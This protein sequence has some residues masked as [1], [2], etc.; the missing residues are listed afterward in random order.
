MILEDEVHEMGLT[1]DRLQIFI[2]TYNRARYLRRTLTQLLAETSPVRNCEIVILDNH[3]TDETRNV[4]HEFASG[5][6]I[7]IITHPRNIGGNGN[8]VR[9]MELA[10]PNSYVWTLGDDDFYDF[11]NWAEVEQAMER[12]EKAIC[13]ARYI[14]P[15]ERKGDIAYKLVQAT[16]ITGMIVHSSIYT[17]TVVSE[18][19]NA[20][21]TLFPQLI[22]VISLVN[23][24][25][26]LFVVDRPIVFNGD[27]GHEGKDVSYCRG[28]DVS[29]ISPYSRHQTWLIGWSAII[30]GLRDWKLRESAFVAGA[31]FLYKTTDKVNIRRAILADMNRYRIKALLPMLAT[32]AAVAPDDIARQLMLPLSVA[33]VKVKFKCMIYRALAK[34]FP[35][36]RD[37]YGFRQAKWERYLLR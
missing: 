32:V 6:N 14:L 19:H 33:K 16:F 30:A 31:S 3:S 29:Q 11:A 18:A 13:L 17:D 9:A 4:A 36:K 22:P 10:R 20:I 35:R 12:G 26:H 7:T 23:H 25:E 28:S 21:H 5:R 27:D 24:D 15:D 37:F 2:I 8:I 1:T 34:A